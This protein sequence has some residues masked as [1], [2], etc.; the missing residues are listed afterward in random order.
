MAKRKKQRLKQAQRKASA[1]EQYQKIALD[2]AC[3]V[4]W[5]QLMQFVEESLRWEEFSL[6]IRVVV[7][8]ANGVPP[9]VEQ[10]LERRIPG[11]LARVREELESADEVG[12]RA[13]NLVG[14]W[15]DNHVLQQPK[16]EGWL[17][18][19]NFF[20]SRTMTYMKFWEHWERMTREWRTNPPAD[21]PSYERWQS[22]VAAVT[23]MRN[24]D[25]EP[26]RIV[27]AMLSVPAAEWE[28]MLSAYRDIVV[29][30]VWME[31][32]LDLE[33]PQSAVVARALAA[34][35]PGFAFSSGDLPST[36]AV[37]ELLAWVI[38]NVVRPPSEEVMGALGW[39]IKRHPEYYA[40]REYAIECHNQWSSEYPDHPPAFREWRQRADQYRVAA[41]AV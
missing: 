7:N 9:V 32:L 18:A 33:G 27:D 8:A 17:N 12:E 34:Q 41:R 35:Y 13:W 23:Q 1:Y 5:P 16:V 10:E 29:F 26:Q 24:P 3:R 6:W 36:A 15:I 28:R 30:G 22:D 4:P 2:E 25:G 31:L 14:A 39:H 37:R 21:W 38:M 20:S 19:V 11:F 40:I